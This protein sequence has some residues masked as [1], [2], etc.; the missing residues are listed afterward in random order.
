M[1]I[2]DSGKLILVDT[3]WLRE[4]KLLDEHS[5]PVYWTIWNKAYGYCLEIL[6]WVF[7]DIV[8]DYFFC[9]RYN[10][11]DSVSSKQLPTLILFQDGKEIKRRPTK[12]VGPD[13]K[14]KLFG[15]T[16]VCSSMQFALKQMIALKNH[17]SLTFSVL[18][19]ANCMFIVFIIDNKTVLSLKENIIK[20]FGLE[21]CLETAKAKLKREQKRN[22]T[23][24]KKKENWVNCAMKILR[25]LFILLYLP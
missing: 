20:A 16:K 8:H 10:I 14:V 3:R 12:S 17:E 1:S 15:F 25:F 9:F 19:G 5:A 4:S 11:D 24:E 18:S 21:T 22:K 6:L 23:D 13:G 7:H 2:W